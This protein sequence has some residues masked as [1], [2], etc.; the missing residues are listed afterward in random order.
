MVCTIGSVHQTCLFCHLCANPDIHVLYLYDTGLCTLVDAL[1]NISPFKKSVYSYQQINL[2]FIVLACLFY[3]CILGINIASFKQHVYIPV[4]Y[5]ITLF[6]PFA[7]MAIH[8]TPLD[9]HSIREDGVENCS[10]LCDIM[11]VQLALYIN[12]KILIMTVYFPKI[13]TIKH[14]NHI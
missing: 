12:I 11:L 2:V 10:D 4:L 7:T 6:S 14:L 13:Y 9:V 8:Y 3:V 5:A 1:I